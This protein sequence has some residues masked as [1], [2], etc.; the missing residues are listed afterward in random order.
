MLNSSITQLRTTMITASDF[1]ILPYTPDMTLAG[2]KYA[3][4]SLPYTYDRMGGNQIKRLR[5]IVAGKG[6]ELAFKRHL[7][8]NQIPHDMLGSTPFTDPDHY[9]IAIG[10]RCCDIKSFLLTQ[11]ERIRQIRANPQQI[12]KAEALVPVDQINSQHFGSEDIYIFAFLMALLTQNQK[13]VMEAITANQPVYLI[14]A[15]PK[16]WSKPTQWG[17]L[18]Q[19]AVK[20]NASQPIKL[21][22]GGQNQQ[23]Q[24]QSEQVILHPQKRRI[25]RAEFAT[26]HYLYTPTLPDGTIGIHSSGLDKTLLIESLSWGNIWVYGIEI[27][28]G[29]YITH[30]EFEQK[31]NRISAGSRVFMYPRTLTENFSIPIQKLHPLQ[32]LFSQAKSWQNNNDR[33]NQ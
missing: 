31:A 7:N 18:G 16:T 25:I 27:I 3:C 8:Q 5:R 28:F 15:L 21:E 20:S 19:L 17:S 14:H 10:G 23:H 13:T 32:A 26:L 24:F 1:I 6:V 11:K 2:I 12:L 9:D 30:A 33:L 29:G 4:Q 22:L